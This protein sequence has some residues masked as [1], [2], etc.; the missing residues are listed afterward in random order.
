MKMKQQI[1]HN[2]EKKMKMTVKVMM[3]ARPDDNSD[4][5][6]D[7]DDD[8][9]VDDDSVGGVSDNVNEGNDDNSVKVQINDILCTTKSGRTYRT[10]KGG[11]LYY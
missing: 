3:K 4:Y 6:D 8:D 9:D 2:K 11:Y 5:D 10:W 7:D 1:L